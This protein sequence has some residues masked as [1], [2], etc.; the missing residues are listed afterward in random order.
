MQPPPL[1]QKQALFYAGMYDLEL[2]VIRAYEK[3]TAEMDEMRW[4]EAL[5]ACEC[6]PLEYLVEVNLEDTQDGV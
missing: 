6:L 2:E 1:T 5:A 4:W 3:S